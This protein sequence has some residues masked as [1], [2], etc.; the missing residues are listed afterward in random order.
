MTQEPVSFLNGH[1]GTS[2][3]GGGPA[4]GNQKNKSQLLN[5]L[6][7]GNG[8]AGFKIKTGYSYVHT[9][10]RGIGPGLWGLINPIHC[11]MGDGT[12][13]YP[14][15]AIELSAEK[16]LDPQRDCVAIVH[17]RVTPRPAG[18]GGPWRQETWFHSAS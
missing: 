13:R 18:R 15:S 5:D 17:R 1:Y 10:E 14:R 7:W 9:A 2:I 12:K 16:Q 11:L 4:G 8:T 6:A 3:R